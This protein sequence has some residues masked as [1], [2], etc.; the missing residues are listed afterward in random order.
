[1]STRLFLIA[2]ATLLASTPALARGKNKVVDQDYKWKIYHTEHF[3]IF[4]YEGEEHLLE[5]IA[6]KV[7]AAYTRVSTKLQHGLSF[8]VPFIYYKTH[9]EFEDT[10]IFPG[11]LPRGVGAFAEPFQ[12][13]MVLPVDLPPEELYALIVHELTHIFQYDMLYN[14]RISTIIRAQAPTWFTEGMASYVADDENNL[15]RMILRDVAVNSGGIS[16]GNFG[17]FSFVAYR[18]GHAAFDYMEET[19]GIEGVRDFL[20]QYRKNIAGNVGGAI[21]RAF[22][23]NPEEFDR[24]FRKYLRKRYVALLP[25][26]E[27]PDDYA[28][29]IRTRRTITTLSPE[30][31]PSG[32]LFAAL[33]PVRNE[34]DLVLISTKDGRIFKNLTRG[35]TNRYT[36]INIGAPFGIND[37]AWNDDGDEIVFAARKEGT[38]VLFV[39]NVLTGRIVDQVGFDDV[40]DAQA[41]CYSKDGRTLYFVGNQRGFF[42][43]FSYNRDTGAVTNH[44]ADQ[45]LD[46]NPRLSP[47]GKEILYS[48]QRDGFYK[49]FSLD[50]ASGEKTQLTSGLG[51]DIQAN[52]N[53][54]MSSIYFSSDRFDDIYNIYE[55]ELE[56]GVKKQYTNVLTGAFSPQERIVFDHKEGEEKR[57]LVFTSYYQGRFRVYRM[58]RPEDREEFYDVARD[59]YAN[60]KDYNMDADIEIDPD[61]RMPYTLKGNFTVSNASV[62]AGA[63]DDGRFISN[64]AVNFSDTLG[65]HDLLINTY[66]VSSFENYYLRYLNR[67]NRWYWGSS[68]GYYAQFFVN[69]Y[70][71]QR[72]EQTY[73]VADTNAF[74]QYPFSTFTR[75][76]GQ[77]GVTDRDYYT[78]TLVPGFNGVL[79]PIVVPADYTEPYASVGLTHDTIRY[80]QY[81]PQH[82]MGLDISAT[83]VFNASTNYAMDFTIYREVT[84]RSLVAFR[85]IANYSDG[86]FPTFYTLGGTNRL[87]ANLDYQ[88]LIGSRR[89]LTQLEYRFPL[90]DA[91]VFPGGV[92]FRNF[93]AAAFVDAGGAWWDDD[94]FNFEF[95]SD[96]D[97]FDP[98]QDIFENNAFNYLLGA[99]GF[100]LSFR[101]AGLDLNW[102]FSQ[103]T[104]FETFSNSYDMDFWI[105]R[106][107]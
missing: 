49:V 38:M 26:K 60:V 61:A 6:N 58:D 75:V 31:S 99:V 21:Q 85:T 71:A 95:Q 7:E 25:E 41:P 42:D 28:R 68:V 64:T 39:V 47:D 33:V 62:Q 103:R 76:E 46:R 72:L 78:Y 18:V 105:G 80:K 3:K 77:V 79:T 67:S 96:E 2:L 70:T 56:S 36:E 40:R 17:A 57:Q 19:Y 102:T 24:D 65:N 51:N 13:R 104:N 69:P 11:F 93:R 5:D 84:K 87:R 20:W 14:N 66:T 4:H 32:D 83:E 15:D 81:G 35:I 23:I 1:L 88:S 101:L 89:V 10:H 12:S 91:I 98:G 100:N 94:Y 48:S 73:R 30:L 34:I 90:V 106:N 45:H 107:F 16:L 8:K 53:T 9:E 22:E 54:D 50:I 63:T 92:A 86:E 27:E 82:G 59:N 44:T 37:L 97:G 29:E 55:L 74:A 52:Y 43:V